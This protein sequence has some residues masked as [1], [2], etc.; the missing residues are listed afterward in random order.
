M[1]S[2]VFDDHGHDDDYDPHCRQQHDPDHVTGCGDYSHYPDQ[3]DD[4][5]CSV[6][7]GFVA[8]DDHGLDGPA[9]MAEGSNA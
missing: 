5:L 9:P 3:D 4:A 7:V 6:Q 8:F 2:V 1:D